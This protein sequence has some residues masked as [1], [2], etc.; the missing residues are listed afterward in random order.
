MTKILIPL[1]GSR[2][3]EEPLHFGLDLVTGS[4]HDITLLKCLD[5]RDWILPENPTS[6]WME[7]RER[8]AT[9]EAQ[10][11]LESRAGTLKSA[12][13]QI[14]YRTPVGQPVVEILRESDQVD[15]ILMCSQGRSGLR[16]F[17]VGSVA[18]EVL[19]KS[20]CPVLLVPPKERRELKR[21]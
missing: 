12:G 9:E 18:E 8:V 5:P 4:H 13:H 2:L 7:K 3:S 10:A 17:F 21:T 20:L 19:R 15:L 1:D 16:R 11:Y 14:S 6:T